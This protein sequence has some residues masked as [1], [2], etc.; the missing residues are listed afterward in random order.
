VWA[1]G[2]FAASARARIARLQA[3]E[4]VKVGMQSRADADRRELVGDSASRGR[5]AVPRDERV[6]EVYFGVGEYQA[7][8][9][10]ISDAV[11]KHSV[12][13]LDDAYVYVGRSQVALK[14][15][16]AARAALMQLKIIP[17]I[18]PRVLRIW[19]LYAATIDR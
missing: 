1:F 2:V 11:E 15:A 19:S 17:N 14:D 13:R 18:S 4:D 8:V 10:S 12:N 6:G 7:A 5:L 16:A 9:A 3:G